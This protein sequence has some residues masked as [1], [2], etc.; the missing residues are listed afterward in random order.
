M[1]AYVYSSAISDE[2]LLVSF[3]RMYHMSWTFV[4]GDYKITMA[5]IC[6]YNFMQNKKQ[7]ENSDISSR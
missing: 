5:M 1:N 4:D 7:D 3:Y 2:M 6:H